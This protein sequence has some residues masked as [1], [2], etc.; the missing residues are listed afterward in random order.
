[1]STERDIWEAGGEPGLFSFYI[2]LD[3]PAF[4]NNLVTK[5]SWAAQLFQGNVAAWWSLKH[6]KTQEKFSSQEYSVA[7]VN[8]KVG[9]LW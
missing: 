5:F 3:S 6:G 2:L 9:L 4:S 7:Y 8:S 1:M